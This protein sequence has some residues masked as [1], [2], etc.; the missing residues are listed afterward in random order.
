MWGLVSQLHAVHLHSHEEA[1][2]TVDSVVEDV[3]KEDDHDH[4][5]DE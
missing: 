4:D 2:H 1:G 3:V 5:H